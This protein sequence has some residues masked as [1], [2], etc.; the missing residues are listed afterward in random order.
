[1]KGSEDKL[2][3]RSRVGGRA[4]MVESNL[5]FPY[6]PFQY[7]ISCLV[8]FLFYSLTVHI[9]SVGSLEK[10]ISNF[11]DLLIS[12]LEDITPMHTA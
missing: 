6:H 3:E 7:L 1:M 12:F 10:G 9:F 8:H 2:G 4:R 11:L 5:D